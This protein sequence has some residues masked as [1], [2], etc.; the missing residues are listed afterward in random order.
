MQGSVDSFDFFRE[1]LMIK[2]SDDA[3]AMLSG[4]QN[5]W[6]INLQTSGA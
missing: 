5:G 6:G 2:L 3:T 4:F 1:G